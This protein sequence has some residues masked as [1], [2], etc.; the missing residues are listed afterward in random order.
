[1]DKENLK[2]NVLK[3]YDAFPSALAVVMGVL[4][5][6]YG[7]YRM[8]L[9]MTD[10]AGTVLP[11]ISAGVMIISGILIILLGRRDLVRTIGLY[12]ISLGFTRFVLRYEIL[13]FSDVVLFVPPMIMMALALNLMFTGISFTRGYVIR[14]K[15]MMLTAAFFAVADLVIILSNSW[16]DILMEILGITLRIDIYVRLLECMMSVVLLLLLDCRQI[17]YGTNLGRY[18]HAMNRIRNS[19]RLPPGP[20]IEPDVADCLTA[21]TGPGWKDVNDGTVVK[22]MTFPV[23]NIKSDIYITAQIWE[24]HD[25][26]F[27]T[28]CS[29]P[30]SIL[31]ANRMRADEIIRTDDV[32]RIYGS[33]GTDFAVKVKEVVI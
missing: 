32:L 20:S 24:G 1:M 33:D 28:V 4:L 31:L 21:R 12:A 14:R 19:Y 5:S 23:H 7:V 16:T 8:Y 9:W 17:R 11:A 22:E 3:L 26:I 18:A 25:T 2:E 6:L 27:M 13:D 15:N 29:N 10:P 30:G